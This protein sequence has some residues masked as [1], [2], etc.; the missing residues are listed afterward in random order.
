MDRF[1]I[2]VTDH[3]FGE[4]QHE[5][6]VLRPL[7]AEVV[8]G[9]CK[10]E[11]EVIE[12]VRDADG[13]LNS[14]VPIGCR[15]I[16]GMRKC[17]VIAYYGTG[18]D[19]IDVGAATERG[20]Y[21]TNVRDY[22]S[23]EVAE[24]VMAF[25]LSLAR[26]I[27]TFDSSVRSGQ[28]RGALPQPVRS[29]KGLKLGLF[30]FGKIA[31]AVAEKAAGPGLAVPGFGRR[32]IPPGPP[33]KPVGFETLLREADFLS[34]HT[35]LT[36]QTQG[37]FG[38]REFRMMKPSAYFINTARGGLLDEKA[39]TRA[40]AEKWIAGAA[41]DVLTLEPP[42]PGNKLLE[43]DSVVL[44]PHVGWF[45][46]DSNQR[47]RESAAREVLRVLRGELPLSAV[48]FEEV[49]KVKSRIQG[50]TVIVQEKHPTPNGSKSNG[51][52]GNSHGN[53][54]PRKRIR[55]AGYIIRYLDQMGVQQIFGVSGGTI[56]PL[57]RAMA[58][59][60]IRDVLTKHECG[61]A[62][63]ADGYARVSGRLGVCMATAG[64][65]ATNLI[66]GVTS[67]Y[68]DSIPLLVLT[69]QVST[70][71]FGRGASQEGSPETADIVQMFKHVTRYSGLAFKASKVPELLRKALTHALHGRKGPVHLSLPTDVLREEMDG[72]PDLERRLP[73]PSAV[74]DREAIRSA[75]TFLLRA[76]H[77][78]MLIG[79]GCVLANA[80]EEARRVAET[81]RIPVAT[82]PKAKGA[83][84]EDHVLSMGCFGFSGSPLADEYMLSGKVDV[85]LAIGTSFNEW[86]TQ[87][88]KK[89]LTPTQALLQIDI[90]PREIGKNY[91]A[92]VPL[93]GDAKTIL[94]ELLYEI[95]RQRNWIVPQ[96]N[97]HFEE[98]AELRS[99]VGMVKHAE[100]MK[101]DELPLKPQRLMADL[102][103]SLPPDALVFVDGGANRSWATHYFP[104]LAPHTFFSATGMASMGYG[105][106]AA[107]G[108][109][110]A[111]PNR[112]VTSIV[113]DGGFLM[114][115]MEVATAV[116]YNKPVIWVV[117]N[118]GRYGM[119]YHG[120]RILGYPTVSSEYPMCD[121]AKVAEG[122]GARGI[123]IFEPGEICPSLIREITESGLPTVL[124][125]RIDP[126]EV[127]LIAER[128]SS[129]KRGFADQKELTSDRV[130]A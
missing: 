84:P 48:N 122:L 87:G 99:R 28:W 125:V 30:G 111:A 10:T 73:A 89:E 40:L 34:L 61:A 88:W 27:P 96:G 119:I 127:P 18:V 41:L 12:F 86:A 7:R 51:A 38:E 64:P 117:L 110:F 112:I 39:L 67:A 109:K 19:A 45:S 55:A 60:G 32:E 11:D 100:K 68:A 107:V 54:F 69:G 114:N 50:E 49:A 2:V 17:K 116:A 130:H 90:D 36:P 26:K 85:L 25:L 65:G 115:G 98:L 43:L 94:V 9:A 77:P 24:H 47:L 59:S 22:C 16:E 92:A 106:A 78:A 66:T 1:K 4:I 21:V 33:L 57:Y 13:V 58:E 53:V 23:H 5:E 56:S 121:V 37:R 74:F 128:V 91:P 31:Q 70:E 76:K 93:V 95:Q 120:R 102:R 123:R 83:L 44:S 80:C 104:A 75:A 124:D 82:T 42:E 105:V 63:M 14:A 46:V 6:E 62:F 108:A 97:G 129:L 113:G 20:I 103:A 81:F 72:I 71:Y 126:E 52:N 35:A 101:S 8:L 118:D 3:R 15:V 29:L 79:N